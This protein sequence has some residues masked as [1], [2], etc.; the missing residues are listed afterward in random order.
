MTEHDFAVLVER[1]RDEVPVGHPPVDLLRAARAARRKRRLK[2]LGITIGA[3]VVVGA[4]GLVVHAVTGQSSSSS[5]G[6]RSSPT[7]PSTP[8]TG[9]S[10]PDT[11]VAPFQATR[12]VGIDGWVV[13][14]PGS[15]GTDQVGCDGTTAI[16]PTV[17]F[18]HHERG[19]PRCGRIR[20]LPREPS[21]HVTSDPV[22]AS[23]WRTISGVAVRRM[24]P[25]SECPTC[26]TLTVPSTSATFEIRART[27]GQLHR[28]ESSLRPVSGRTI[29]VPVWQAPVHGPAALD[30][31][32][33][34]ALANGLRPQ[35]VEMPDPEPPG[36]FLASSPPMGTPVDSG[37]GI[38]IFY[39]A[40]DLASYA[41][42]TSLRRH[43]WDISAAGDFA[44]PVTRD[45]AKA[46]AARFGVHPGT[47][48]FLRTLTIVHSEPAGQRIQAVLAWLVVSGVEQRGGRTTATLTA[49][50]AVKGRV[51]ETR[52]GFVGRR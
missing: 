25:T 17:V 40:G 11:G 43:G 18:D 46:A 30:Q 12:E 20:I 1:N 45:Q 32:T 27:T 35:T 23:R 4:G 47:D 41:T 3:V 8:T 48:V 5:A 52:T 33:Q 22:P 42:A 24:A 15:W 31:M 28:I 13:T 16:R 14:V 19:R 29:T 2:G 38:T 44:P 7:A 26:A 9:T 49:V 39:S 34:I 6:T 10:P 21:V 51:L 36:T 50:D 37:R